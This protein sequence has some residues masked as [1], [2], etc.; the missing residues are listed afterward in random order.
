MI[1]GVELNNTSA[2]GLNGTSAVGQTPVTNRTI[3][4]G[5]GTIENAFGQV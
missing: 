2:V 1:N 5:T 3:P 4:C